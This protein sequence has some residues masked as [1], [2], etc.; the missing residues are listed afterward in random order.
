MLK[1]YN[2]SPIAGL[3]PQDIRL[4]SLIS[5]E[6]QTQTKIVL[7]GFPVDEGVRRNGGRAGARFAP[8]AIRSN[9]YRWV[10][11]IGLVAGFIADVG[12]ID[13]ENLSL[14]EAQHRL[15]DVVADCLEKGLFP[16]V[17]GGGHETA[18]GH[19][20]A[21]TK[22]KTNVSIINLDAHT[23][24]RDLKSGLGHSGSP[25]LQAMNHSS[26]ALEAYHVIGA[27]RFA[28][29]EHHADRV[30]SKGSIQW[31]GE[32][33]RIPIT[34]TETYLT[35]DLDVI[36]QSEMPGVSATNPNGYSFS[37]LKSLVKKIIKNKNLRSVDIVELNPLVDIQGMSG[38][39]AAQLLYTIIEEVL[40]R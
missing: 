14:D 17:L 10:P 33:V 13:C 5:Q 11:Q 15:G 6:I 32:E 7:I 16:I 24:V 12:N 26:K 18:Y 35:V 37:E 19:F 40:K 39:R 25:F 30:R 1:P 31:M 2:F 8:D 36:D 22:R 3:E 23:D 9:L 29:A 21:Y 4:F 27:Q 38:K 20:L 28:V 34:E